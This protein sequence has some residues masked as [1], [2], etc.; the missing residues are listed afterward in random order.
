MHF[1]CGQGAKTGPGGHLPGSKVIGKIA[2]VRGLKP[3]TESISPS[4]FTDLVTPADFKEFADRAR[5]VSGGMPIGFKMSGNRIKRDINFA[6][7]GGADYIIL[8]GRGLAEERFARL[9]EALPAVT[10]S[11]TD[12]VSA[13]VRSQCS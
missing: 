3:S 10:C 4:A 12:G 2:E 1:K 8:D 6:L 13:S 9:E 11:S 7:A 5:E